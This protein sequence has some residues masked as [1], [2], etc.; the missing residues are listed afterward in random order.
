MIIKH[1]II[2][3]FLMLSPYIYDDTLNDESCISRTENADSTLP[4]LAPQTPVLPTSRARVNQ[5]FKA[6]L[7]P[8]DPFP[9]LSTPVTRASSC[10]EVGCTTNFSAARPDWITECWLSDTAQRVT[11]T[12]GWWRTG[13]DVITMHQPRFHCY[14][15]V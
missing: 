10:T 3:R 11:R 9:L 2:A 15:F 13:N 6:P 5:I 14:P 7:L 12:T 1:Y 4:M 8:S